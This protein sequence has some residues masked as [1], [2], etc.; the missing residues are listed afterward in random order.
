[1][2]TVPTIIEACAPR[3]VN[4]RQ[5]T[6]STSAG[7]L[8][9]AAIANARPTMYATFWPLKTIPSRTDAIPPSTLAARATTNCSCSGAWPP[10]TTFTHRSCESA[11]APDSVRPATTA[12]MVANATAAMNPRNGVPPNVSARSGAAMLPPG[13]TA[14]IA[15]GPTSTIAPK[16]STNVIR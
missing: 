1:M 9:L 4:P 7:K 5:N 13:S 15:S 3:V 16:P 11:A 2:D 14:R 8:A 10:R 12:R 6:A